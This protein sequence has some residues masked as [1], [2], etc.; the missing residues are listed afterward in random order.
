MPRRRASETYRNRPGRVSTLSARTGTVQTRHEIT[1]VVRS[2]AQSNQERDE[3]SGSTLHG[4]YGCVRGRWLH[5][6]SRLT[7]R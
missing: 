5:V 3:E 1:H 2:G 4:Q 7:G 6:V